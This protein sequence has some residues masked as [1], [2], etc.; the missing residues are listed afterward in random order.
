MF[1]VTKRTTGS[2][3]EGSEVVGEFNSFDEAYAKALTICEDVCHEGSKEF[4]YWISDE[5]ND[6]P[7]K[8]VISRV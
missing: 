6:A 8:V 5:N 1:R 3:N 4:N 2:F 7:Y